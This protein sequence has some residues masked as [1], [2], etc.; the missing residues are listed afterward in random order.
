MTWI[1]WYM[2]IDKYRNLL[3]VNMHEWYKMRLILSGFCFELS[4]SQGL[5][6]WKGIGASIWNAFSVGFVKVVILLVQPIKICVKI[7]IPNMWVEGK[8]KLCSTNENKTT[9]VD[10]SVLYWDSQNTT[11]ARWFW[12]LLIIINYQSF[13]IHFHT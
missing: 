13:N 3:K 12:E 9:F 5:H 4:F 10:N 11:L 1:L 2:V 8:S 6:H 7:E